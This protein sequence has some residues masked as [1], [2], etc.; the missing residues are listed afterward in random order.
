MRRALELAVRGQGFVEPN[1]MVGCVIARGAEIIGEGFHRRFGGPHAE[2]EALRIAGDRAAGATLYVTLEPCCHQGKT[3]PCTQAVLASGV[4]RVVVAQ[5]D[6]FPKVQGGGIAAL[7]AAG[8]SVDVG[9]LQAEAQRTRRTLPEARNAGPAVDHRQVGHDARRQDRHAHRRE[10]LDLQPAVAADRA[11]APRPGR[12]N[13]GGAGNGR[14]RRSALD[15]PPPGTTHRRP[16]G[17][18]H[19]RLASTANA[20]WCVPRQKHRC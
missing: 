18:G 11:C 12:C 2:V 1:P 9:L 4:R 8:L 15:R 19:P 13:Y 6:P 3:P 14:T 16:R 20:N 10:P 7:R 5:D 17:V